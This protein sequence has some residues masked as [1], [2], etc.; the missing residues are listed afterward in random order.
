M[1]FPFFVIPGL[2]L[3]EVSASPPGDV[4]RSPMHNPAKT[5]AVAA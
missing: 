1:L 3:C 5:K 4:I 2:D